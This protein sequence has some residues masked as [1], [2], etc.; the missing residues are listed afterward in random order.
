M[1]ALLNIHL[2]LGLMINYSYDIDVNIKKYIGYTS[3]S[4]F[5]ELKN[6]QIVVNTEQEKFSTYCKQIKKLTIENLTNNPLFLNLL[7]VSSFLI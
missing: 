3:L 4:T 6:C 2:F 1:M 5:V 7:Q